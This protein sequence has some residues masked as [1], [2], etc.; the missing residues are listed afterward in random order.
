MLLLLGKVERCCCCWGKL[1]GVVVVEGV[2]SVPL[3]IFGL[4]LKRFFEFWC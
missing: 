2:V 4:L 3:T 1:K